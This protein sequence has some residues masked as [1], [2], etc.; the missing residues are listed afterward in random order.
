MREIRTA[1]RISVRNLPRTDHSGNLGTDRC[2]N[3]EMD[4]KEIECDDSTRS[5][6]AQVMDMVIKFQVNK[7]Q[8][9]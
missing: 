3:T 4:L 8:E 1:K 7:K 2:D 9:Y 6:N 5:G